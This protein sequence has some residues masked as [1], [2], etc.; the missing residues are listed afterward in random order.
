MKDLI[1]RCAL[2][3]ATKYGGKAN[4]NAALGGLFARKKNIDKKKAIELCRKIIAEVNS[5][6]L[7]EQ[8]ERL[9]ELGK[10]KKL[11]KKKKEICLE[12]TKGKVVM[13]FAPNP[14]GPMSFGHSRTALWNWF[15]VKQYKGKYVLRFDDTDPRIKVP[16]KEAYQWFKE[17]LKWLGVKV[18]VSQIQSRRL[19]LYYKYAEK[20]IKEGNAYVDTLPADKMR[21]MLQKRLISDERNDPVRVVMKKWKK[22]FTSFKDGEAVLRIKTDINHPNPA[23]RDWAAFRIIKRGKHPL[24]KARVWPLLNFCSAIDDHELG[25]T[26]IL[27]GTDLKVSDQR[28]KFIY[29][30][31]GWRY[32]KTRYNG[33]FFVS[34][35]QSTSEASE[36]IKEGKLSG[37]EDPRLGTLRALRRRGYQAEA[38]INFIKDQ[39]LGMNDI[40][41]NIESLA[42]YNKDVIDKGAK[43]YFLILNPQKVVIEDAKNKLV[44][45]PLHP[46]FPKKGNRVFR[47]EK[48][49]YVQDVFEPGKVYR[50]MH[51]FNF[52]NLK[53][54]SFDHDEKLKAKL[55]HWL[56]VSKTL[57]RVEVIMPDNSVVKGYGERDLRKVKVNE[58]IQAERIGFMRCDKK[59]K[60]KM[61]FYFGHR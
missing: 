52:K 57:N 10:L 48:N 43:R 58:V 27:R 3:N 1:L 56:P 18:D 55:V 5:L 34:G 4:Y 16:M 14:N 23:V 35:I 61:V 39:G 11:S 13:R 8:K 40:N 24:V 38:L 37:W 49:F 54:T 25:V 45:A 46:D 21:V 53:F 20:L 2:E 60:N 33:K 19:K 36:L 22:M 32:P 31:F 51:L 28:Q 6:S 9:K 47:T 7:N 30:Y 26:H 29:D 50:F 17:D 15:F 12:R 59:L 41:V 42:A 44:K